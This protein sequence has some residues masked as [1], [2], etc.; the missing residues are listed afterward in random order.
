VLE[1][2]IRKRFSSRKIGVQS[3]E[4]PPLMNSQSGCLLEP[5]RPL[6]CA[7]SSIA[8]DVWRLCPWLLDQVDETV[9]TYRMNVRKTI[10]C[11]VRMGDKAKEQEQDVDRYNSDIKFRQGDLREFIGK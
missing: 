8:S 2:Y 9:N 7:L 3:R 5:Y 6:F 1:D 4:K 10:V 11:H